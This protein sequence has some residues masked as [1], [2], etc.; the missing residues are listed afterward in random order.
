[1]NMVT[2]IGAGPA[3]LICAKQTQ[4]MGWE[5][6]IIEDH[7]VIGKPVNCTGIISASGVEELRIKKEVDEVLINKIRGAQIFSPNHEMIEIK[8]SSTVAY[9]IDRGEFDRVLARNAIEA[10]AKLKLNTKMIDIR[11]ETIFTEHKG[12]GEL[13]KSK[14][15]VG[16]DGV[17]SKTRNIIGINTGIKDL[18]NNNPLDG[19]D[20]WGNEVESDITL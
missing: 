18:F 10:G 16:A 14:L 6:T 11:N 20:A 1:M 12:R 4:E 9:V 8:R 19:W 2:V 15:I 5:T 13:L 7:G 17:N 3:G